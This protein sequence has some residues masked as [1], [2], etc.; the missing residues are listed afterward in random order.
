VGLH[1][2]DEHVTEEGGHRSI[3][4]GEP[5]HQIQISVAVALLRIFSTR[6]NLDLIKKTT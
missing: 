4:D 1:E 2:A 5:V 3:G 6:F